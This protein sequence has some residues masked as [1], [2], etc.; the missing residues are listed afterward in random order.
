ML[1]LKISESEAEV[2]EELVDR[3][4]S[5]IER[6]YPVIEIPGL[7]SPSQIVLNELKKALKK[8][9][10]KLKV[11]FCGRTDSDVDYDTYA[12]MTYL[13]H[14]EGCALHTL[15]TL[16]DHQVLRDKA[17]DDDEAALM[18]S[19]ILRLQSALDR[20]GYSHRTS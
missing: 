12:L 19:A 9:F 3:E 20:A 15:T 6:P 11:A 16:L 14:E 10:P 18:S 13:K 17:V 7:S 5:E 2:L 8:T 1:T 4:L